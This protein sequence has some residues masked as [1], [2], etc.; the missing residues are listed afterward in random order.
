MGGSHPNQGTPC[1]AARA[2]GVAAA[3][4]GCCF[5]DGCYVPSQEQNRGEVAEK[6]PGHFTTRGAC[7]D[8]QDRELAEE[9]EGREDTERT[10]VPFAFLLHRLKASQSPVQQ[11]A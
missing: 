1:K 2:L 6:F 10:F 8:F 3:S 5:T 9:A 7:S 11:Q 4:D